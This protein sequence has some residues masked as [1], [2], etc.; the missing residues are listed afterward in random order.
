MKALYF[1]AL[2]ESNAVAKFSISISAAYDAALQE[3][4]DI[5]ADGRKSTL[6]GQLIEL[7]LEKKYPNRF[8]SAPDELPGDADP[9]ELPQ[10]L[11]L[12]RIAALIL[13]LGGRVSSPKALAATAIRGH[14][15]RWLQDYA[16]QVEEIAKEYGLSFAQCY[17]ML[18]RLDAPYDDSDIQW[19]KAQ[20][21]CP[22]TMDKFLKRAPAADTDL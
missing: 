7:S 15:Q 3:W 13:N 10:D 8:P 16:E 19:A 1:V 18:T 20:T 22:M 9:Y 12:Q 21:D 6:A 2:G 5:V 14:F 4:A 11:R 17:E